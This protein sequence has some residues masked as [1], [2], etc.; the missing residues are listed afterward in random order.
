MSSA[1]RGTGPVT[2]WPTGRTRIPA[3]SYA[4]ALQSD[5][6]WDDHGVPV[7]RERPSE[8]VIADLRRTASGECQPTRHF[9]PS[10]RCKRHQSAGDAGPATPERRRCWPSDTRAPAMRLDVLAGDT[11]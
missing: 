4:G 11:R 6:A 8:I 9:R 7:G 1:R 3:A 2:R 5:Y 10:L